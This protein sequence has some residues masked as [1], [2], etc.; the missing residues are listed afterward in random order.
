[1]LPRC[2]FAFSTP[3]TSVSVAVEMLHSMAH[4]LRTLLTAQGFY[5]SCSFCRWDSMSLEVEH[6]GI[7][8]FVD[9]KP[10]QLICAPA[11]LMPLLVQQPV[12]FRNRRTDSLLP[13]HSEINEA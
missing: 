1:M 12:A 7:E 9:E 10:D 4:T 8:P 6:L 5:L 2:P 3:S 11:R 13:G